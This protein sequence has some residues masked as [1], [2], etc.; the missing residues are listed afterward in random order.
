M[1]DP[2]P[3]ASLHAKVSVGVA[4]LK[5]SRLAIDS[6]HSLSLKTRL[7]PEASSLNVAVYR[8]MSQ[9]RRFSMQL[10]LDSAHGVCVKLGLHG[11][12]NRTKLVIPI[13]LSQ[14]LSPTAVLFG[15][16]VPAVVYSAVRYFEERLPVWLAKLL[17]P[18]PKASF[19]SQ[20]ERL[21]WNFRK[22]QA[23]LVQ[24][25]L[26]PSHESRKAAANLQITEARFG[27]TVAWIDVA[28]PVQ[29]L[30]TS[31]SPSGR[32]NR[33]VIPAGTAFD[34]LLGFY[35]PLCSS[36]DGRCGLRIQYRFD[37]LLHQAEFHPGQAVVLPQR[38]HLIKGG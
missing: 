29:F 36:E 12:A 26:T 21:L 37:S 24:A 23:D 35:N 15:S 38:S 10:L 16:V 22:D 11:H 3:P 2:E 6:H 34:R 30:C 1:M 33:L 19:A 20:E 18:K 7:T 5:L 28:V 31:A 27:T 8:K 14:E 13:W 25:L 17:L 32:V 9:D 4:E